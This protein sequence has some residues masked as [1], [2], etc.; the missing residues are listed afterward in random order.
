MSTQDAGL[1]SEKFQENR[2]TVLNGA[3]NL[4]QEKAE[5]K[6]EEFEKDERDKSEATLYVRNSRIYPLL[7]IGNSA[8]Y[9]YSPHIV[10]EERYESVKY[11][12]GKG[13]QIQAEKFMEE[14]EGDEF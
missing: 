14:T 1:G 8:Y 13:L 2:T 5:E 6:L 11:K 10:I 9:N 4:L 3:L 7:G 12:S